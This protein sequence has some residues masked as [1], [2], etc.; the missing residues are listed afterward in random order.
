MLDD[1]RLQKHYNK[2]NSEQVAYARKIFMD[3]ERSTISS[4]R[5]IKQGSQWGKHVR[6]RAEF[7]REMH[8]ANYK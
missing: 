1:S 3:H 8:E 4:I 2:K 6:D 5:R 7:T